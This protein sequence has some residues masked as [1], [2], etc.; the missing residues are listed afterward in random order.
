MQTKENNYTTAPW[1]LSAN[2]LQDTGTYH[3]ALA[4]NIDI[5]VSNKQFFLQWGN[6]HSSATPFRE[7][8]Q[9]RVKFRPTS[10]QYIQFEMFEN[11]PTG[12]IY[13]GLTFVK[14]K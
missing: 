6:L 1:L 8:D 11:K 7:K 4:G 12:L 9:M 5:V 2:K 10:G 13:D 14:T 3:H